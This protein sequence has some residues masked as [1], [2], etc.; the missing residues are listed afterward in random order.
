MVGMT[1]YQT[2]TDEDDVQRDGT[3][4]LHGPAGFEGMRKAGRLAAEILDEPA[5]EHQ[6]LH[7]PAACHALTALN[8]S[9]S[10]VGSVSAPSASARVILRACTSW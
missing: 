7:P 3:I 2:I 5:L 8:M 4:K 10:S 9:L 6:P 1:Q